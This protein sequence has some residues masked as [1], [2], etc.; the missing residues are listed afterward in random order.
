MLLLLS[1]QCRQDWGPGPQ[2]LQ[3]WLLQKM[4]WPAAGSCKPLAAPRCRQQRLC[5][6]IALI[7]SGRCTMAG[8][9]LLRL[10]RVGSSPRLQRAAQL[11]PALCGIGVYTVA[12]SSEPARDFRVV[13]D[14]QHWAQVALFLV[15]G[16]LQTCHCGLIY[17]RTFP[18]QQPP[19]FVREQPSLETTVLVIDP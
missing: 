16:S 1:L 17:D 12:Q 14:A 3:L 15:K 18:M 19:A 11:R 13:H 4:H 7:T 8:L 9:A 10:A 2:A 6:S 5:C